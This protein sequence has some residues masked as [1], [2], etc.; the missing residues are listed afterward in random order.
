MI[1]KGFS[2][3]LPL[4][5]DG[6]PVGF[7]WREFGRVVRRMFRSREFDCIVVLR[8]SIFWFIIT[9]GGFISALS[10]PLTCLFTHLAADLPTALGE[11]GSSADVKSTTHDSSSFLIVNSTSFLAVFAV[12]G[13]NCRF[14]VLLVAS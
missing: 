8:L 9:V 13:D 14:D 7:I 3:F 1:H 11:T 2:L 6:G 10:L 4:P 12:I 5:L